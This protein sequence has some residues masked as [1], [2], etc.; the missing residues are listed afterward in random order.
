M[1]STALMTAIITV[2]GLVF[3]FARIGLDRILQFGIWIDLAVTAGV[4]LIF[5]GSATGILSAA[6]TGALLSAV[7]W[8]IA[9]RKP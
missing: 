4:L 2:I 8:F 5:Q 1:F 9:R 7:L 3:I 6:L